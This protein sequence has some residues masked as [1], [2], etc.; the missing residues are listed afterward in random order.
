MHLKIDMHGVRNREKTKKL[1]WQLD[2]KSVF[3][4][5][6]KKIDCKIFT[7]DVDTFPTVYRHSFLLN[8]GTENKQ[9]SLDAVPAQ[10]RNKSQASKA[11]FSD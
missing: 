3:V 6:E 9:S 4:R 10:K 8:N 11:Y 5:R 7:W 2:V 1:K